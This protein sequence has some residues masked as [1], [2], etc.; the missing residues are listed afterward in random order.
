[1]ESINLFMS[2]RLCLFGEHSDWAGEYRRKD[3]RMPIGYC[4][5]VGTDQGIYATARPHQNKFIITSTLPD[6]RIEGPRT[7]DMDEYSLRVIAQRGE[8]FSYCAGVVSCLLKSHKIEGM[9]IEGTRMDLPIMKGLSSSAAICILVARAFNW[10]YDLKL[11]KRGEMELAYQG[12]IMTPSRCGR[13]DQACAYGNTPVLLTFNGDYM[14]VEVLHTVKPIYMV[15]VDLK[16]GK[17]TMKILSDLNTEYSAKH[18]TFT[19]NLQK[20]LGTFNKK[21]VFQAKKAIEEGDSQMIGMLMKKAQ[22][23]FDKY[24]MPVCPSELA[25]PK[26]HK[27]LEYPRIQSLVWGGKGVGSQGDGSAQFIARGPEEQKV[28]IEKLEREF[29]VVCLSL[30]I[31]PNRKEAVCDDMHGEFQR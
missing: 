23:L 27:V 14:E 21:V 22:V 13:M 26:L 5:I 10:V 1:M 4:L 7:F 29:D 16:K 18:G 24:I 31:R 9:V 17:N 28:L 2:G 19:R 20:A 11:T 25:A 12:E 30:T 6:G 8:F 15:I 3:T